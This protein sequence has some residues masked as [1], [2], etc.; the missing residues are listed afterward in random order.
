MALSEKSAEIER[1]VQ[2]FEREADQFHHLD[3][4]TFVI[5]QDGPSITR[6]FTSPNHVI[7]L[8]QYYGS[9]EGD[10]SVEQFVRDLQDS[11]LQWGARG[12][13][14]GAFGLL[15]GEACQLFVRMATRAGTL[16]DEEEA[17]RIRS[18]IVTEI[19]K[20]QQKKNPS[21]K[22]AGITNDNPLA[23]WLNFLLFHLSLTNPG[24]ERARR[25]EPDP[26]SLSLIALERLAAD[27]T[28]GKVDRSTR[29]LPS[30]RFKVAVSFPG[31]KRRYVSRVVDGLRSG[32]GQDSVFYDYDYQAQ[33]ARPNLDTLLQRIYREQADLIV[34]F[35]CAEYASKEWCGLEWRVLRD[36]IKKKE[37]ER[38]MFIRF[39]D[40]SVDGLLSIDGYIDAGT[41]SAKEVVDL[42]LSRVAS[43]EQKG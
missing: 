25:I 11:N 37:D 42:I 6:T 34:V 4:H 5:T 36:I 10:P 24:R 21:G 29:K 20:A 2:A 1:L 39:D 32:L 40:A 38:V 35:L 33:L 26:F 15:E 7:M 27:Q 18:R 12:C 8:W 22:P 17:G 43:L 23:I 19:L 14:L 3:F 28:I 9:L 16:F 41:H 31:E 30:L 13:S